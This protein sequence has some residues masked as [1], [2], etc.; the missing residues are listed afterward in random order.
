MGVNCFGLNTTA[1]TM[2]SECLSRSSEVLMMNSASVKDR[3]WFTQVPTASKMDAVRSVQTTLAATTNWPGG[4]V[5]QSSAVSRWVF[6]YL[7]TTSTSPTDF[8]RVARNFEDSMVDSDICTAI[9]LTLN[10]DC[11]ARTLAV[12]MM[13]CDCNARTASAPKMECHCSARA[14]RISITINLMQGSRRA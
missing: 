12:R 14:P 7:W 6:E 1:S 8:D 9:A 13:S 2:N 5:T 11:P 3:A 4:Y 10:R